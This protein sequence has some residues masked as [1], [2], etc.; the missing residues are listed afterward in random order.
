V[1]DN[2]ESRKFLFGILV[3]VLL[4]LLGLAVAAAFFVHGRDSEGD[5]RRN[6]T[7]AEIRMLKSAVDAFE[8]DNGRLPSEQEALD[9]LLHAPPGLSATW[10]GPYIFDVAQ[11]AWGRDFVYVVPG[12][13]ASRF[14]II[15]AGQ[16][17]VFG[18]D[19]DMD[20]ETPGP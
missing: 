4:A 15:S 1:R 20:I 8:I 18:D 12:P 9:A 10:R 2:P 6:A 17:C 5:Y 13:G 7:L 19:D 3:L 16:N 14:N 11:D